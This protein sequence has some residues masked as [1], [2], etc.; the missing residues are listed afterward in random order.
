MLISLLALA[1]TIVSDPPPFAMRVDSARHEVFMTLGPLHLAPT[2]AGV[3][4]A[5]A[6]SSAHDIPLLPLTWPVAGWARGFRVRIYDAEGRLLSRRILHH[7]ELL[8]LERRRLTESTFERTFAAGQETADLM[9]PSSVGVRLEAGAEMAILAAF[10]NETTEALHDVTLEV[11]VVYLPDDRTP[12]PREIRPVDIDV[13]LHAGSSNTF[14][15]APGRTVYQ[16]DFTLPVSGRL[17]GVGGHLHDYAES[18]ALLD[19]TGEKVLFTLKAKRDSAG[20]VSGVGRKLF[21]VFGEGLKLRAGRIY[22]VSAVYQ[23]PFERTLVDGGMALLGGI[24]APD[25]PALWPPL[26]RTD[27]AF[28][29][30][31]GAL[32]RLGIAKVVSH[33]TGGHEHK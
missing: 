16:R 3:G 20:K 24:F 7:V 21:A 1:A 10:A 5:E 8:H 14:D 6:H 11:V 33:A 25:N 32:D 12:R 13:L 19:V 9:L 2:P 17:L 30:D 15:V 28:L 26:D 23:N 4:H 27:P 22:R 31:K 29:A 18:I